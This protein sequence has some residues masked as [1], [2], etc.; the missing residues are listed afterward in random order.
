MKRQWDILYRPLTLVDLQIKS[1][2]SVEGQKFGDDGKRDKKEESLNVI[3]DV[4]GVTQEER[5]GLLYFRH[6]IKILS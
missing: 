3:Q 5:G 6:S 2:K 1:T 4:S